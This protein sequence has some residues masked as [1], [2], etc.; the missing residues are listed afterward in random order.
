M[1]RRPV[2]VLNYETKKVVGEFRSINEACEMLNENPNTMHKH[3]KGEVKKP[4]YI[5]KDMEDKFYKV[6]QLFD[7]ERNLIKEGSVEEVAAYVNEPAKKI[8]KNAYYLYKI[9]KKYMVELKSDSYE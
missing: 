9:Q 8:I 7:L 4:I 2:Q 1:T 5:I 3:L 6:Y